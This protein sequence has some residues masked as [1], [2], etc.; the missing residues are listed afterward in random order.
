MLLT[1][2]DCQRRDRER[3][4]S[5]GFAAVAIFTMAL[6]VGA[7]T[8]MF[9]VVYNVLIDPFPYKDFNRSVVFS[10]RGLNGEPR[11]RVD[12]LVALRCE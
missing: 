11:T 10:V 9:S 5:P 8:V 7:A 12:P 4:K 3:S 1:C 6:G 2:Y